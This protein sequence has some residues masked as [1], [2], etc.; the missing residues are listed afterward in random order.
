MCVYVFFRLKF[1]V[2][3]HTGRTLGILTLSTGADHQEQNYT[4]HIFHWF[5]LAS[6]SGLAPRT[7]C[8]LHMAWAHLRTQ[9]SFCPRG[10]RLIQPLYHHAK[11]STVSKENWETRFESAVLIQIKNLNLI[12]KNAKIPSERNNSVTTLISCVS[13]CLESCSSKNVA[14]N[15]CL[16][17]HL[18]FP[19][20]LQQV[21]TW[22]VSRNVFS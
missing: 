7:E 1:Y 12:L 2:L 3:T 11:Q 6:T 19:E 4:L 22:W 9:F 14:A 13:C 8:P 16:D 5:S 18:F 17:C 15:R 20:L 21:P 10:T